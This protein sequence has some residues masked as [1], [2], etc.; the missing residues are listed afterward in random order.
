MSLSMPAMKQQLKKSGRQQTHNLLFPISEHMTSC[1]V[2]HSTLPPNLTPPNSTPLSNP[3]PA[4]PETR[5]HLASQPFFQRHTSA[6]HI[7]RSI[8]LRQ[9]RYPDF[10]FQ[11]PIA[12]LRPSS[13]FYCLFSFSIVPSLSLRHV[14]A[15]KKQIS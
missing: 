4:H 5:R 7:P 8:T 1:Q 3:Q 11:S 6:S 2:R 15:E 10:R 12:N 13:I 14:P 9:D